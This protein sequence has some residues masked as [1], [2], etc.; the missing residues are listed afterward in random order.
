MPRLGRPSW[1][2]RA[3]SS[4]AYKQPAKVPAMV[5]DALATVANPLNRRILAA[6]ALEPAHARRLAALIGSA[7][8]EVSRRLK[9]MERLGLLRSSWARSPSNVKLY[10]LAARSMQVDLA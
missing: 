9:A 1:G 4:T 5:A 10:R 3:A 6:L 7:E 2:L 8:A